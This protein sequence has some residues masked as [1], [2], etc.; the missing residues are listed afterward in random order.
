MQTSLIAVGKLRPQ[1]RLVCDDYLRRLRRYGPVEERELRESARAA[2]TTQRRQ[3]ETA[4][5]EAAIP[6]RGTV[7]ALEMGGALWSSEELARRLDQWR[8]AA[9]PV[10]LV[11]GGAF[12]LT[13]AFAAGARF[14]WSLGPLTLPHELVRV[15]VLEQWYRAWTILRGEPYH[16]GGTA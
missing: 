8:A 11:I 13:P 1:F 5:L 10:A 14:R 4:R 16:K 3:E 9:A 2:T 7:I 15:I 6:P 12:G